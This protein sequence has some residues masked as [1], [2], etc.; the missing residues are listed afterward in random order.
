M[1][2]SPPSRTC[3]SPG[4]G[5]QVRVL[6]HLP[7]PAAHLFAEAGFESQPVGGR[8]RQERERVRAVGVYAHPN[9]EGGL[10]QLVERFIGVPSLA[11]TGMQRSPD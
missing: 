3:R 11:A 4:I 6:F 8:Q 1:T 9:F 10:Q 7:K 2:G 5:E